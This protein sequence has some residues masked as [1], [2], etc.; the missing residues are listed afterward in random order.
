MRRLSPRVGPA[1]RSSPTAPQTPTPPPATTRTSP[2]SPTSGSEPE[3]EC[4]YNI[5][6]DNCQDRVWLELHDRTTTVRTSYRSGYNIH[7]RREIRLLARLQACRPDRQE[8]TLC[9]LPRL[10]SL[11]GG[12]TTSS[13]R[14]AHSNK[15][16]DYRLQSRHPRSPSLHGC[17]RDTRTLRDPP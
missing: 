7:T 8:L 6:Q 13:G 2:M 16:S 4:G 9:R 10:T 14:R 1:R 15:G 5:C 11:P 17:R 12:N 3:P